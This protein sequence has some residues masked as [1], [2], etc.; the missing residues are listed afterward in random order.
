MCDKRGLSTII[1]VDGGQTGLTMRQVVEAGANAIV[2]GTAVFGAA[3]YA[4]AIAAIRAGRE[5]R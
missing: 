5:A 3:D 1:E 2:A 4:D